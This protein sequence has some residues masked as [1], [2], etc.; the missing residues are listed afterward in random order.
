[1]NPALEDTAAE[2]T[3]VVEGEGDLAISVAAVVGMIVE[4]GEDR[5]VEVTVVLL[6][7]LVMTNITVVI[8]HIIRL[9]ASV[10]TAAESTVVAA[11]EGEP[12]ISVVAV[13]GMI[14]VEGEDRVAAVIVGQAVVHLVDLVMIN[15]NTL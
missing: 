8:I 11:G 1:M 14:A 10:G 4:E 2:G 7:G 12:A 3:V 9:P 6:V 5:I 15:M 13:V